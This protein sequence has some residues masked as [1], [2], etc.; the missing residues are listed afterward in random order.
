[1][2]FSYKKQAQETPF[3]LMV[4]CGTYD[5][6]SGAVTGG[7]IYTGLN[8]VLAMVIQPKGAVVATDQSAVVDTLPH[9][10]GITI[11]TPASQVGTWIAV[12]Y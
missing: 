1:M 2:A 10:D 3:G 6:T 11:I 8:T 12:G 7:K 4:S 5:C 9:S